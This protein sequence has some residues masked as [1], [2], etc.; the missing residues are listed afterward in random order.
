M[1]METRSGTERIGK[2][3]QFCASFVGRKGTHDCPARAAS[4]PFIFRDNPTQL[5]LNNANPVLRST[6]KKKKNRKL[7]L[8]PNPQCK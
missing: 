6:Q 4:I 8:L 3:T 7:Q 2:H 1:N 5:D